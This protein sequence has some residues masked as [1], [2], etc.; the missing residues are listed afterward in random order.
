MC[1]IHFK[2]SAEIHAPLETVP[3]DGPFKFVVS[4]SAFAS[5]VTIVLSETGSSIF[6][7]ALSQV[8]TRLH[9]SLSLAS[10]FDNLARDIDV[11]LTTLVRRLSTKNRSVL[12]LLKQEMHKY[13]RYELCNGGVYWSDDSANWIEICGGTLSGA[14][15]AHP[16]FRLD[17]GWRKHV[18]SL[19]DAGEESLI[20]TQHLHEAERSSGLE[21]QWIEATIAAELA[22]KEILIRLEPKLEVLL[23][24]VPSPPL[25]K[26]YGEVLKAVTGEEYPKRG[27]LQKGADKRNELVHRP[28]SDELD[29]QKVVDYLQDVRSAIEHLLKVDRQRRNQSASAPKGFKDASSETA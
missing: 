27:V 12:R 9:D 24:K 23:L 10:T 2:V 1:Q 28:Q 25:G 3:N 7:T 15:S 14:F 6:S 22:I 13:D 26:L 16:L 19:L 5:P 18:Q 17:A 21:F 20:A 8:S 11:E 4:D 29:P